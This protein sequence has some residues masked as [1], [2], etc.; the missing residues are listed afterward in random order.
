MHA[1]YLCFLG[2]L[3]LL[4]TMPK[5]D[6]PV[7]FYSFETNEPFSHCIECNT[8]LLD[9]KTEYLVEKA[10]KNYQGYKAT[11]VIFDYAICMDCAESRRKAISSESMRS[12]MRYFQA[13]IS[14]EMRALH[15]ERSATENLNHCLVKGISREECD[16]F[17]IFAHCVGRQLHESNP[18]YMVCSQV[19]E[20][21]ITELSAKTIDEMNGFLTKHFSPDPSFFNTTPKLVL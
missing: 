1:Y 9:E 3:G 5:S 4:L 12:I 16:E 7:D 17:Q 14:E 11:D 13:N 20:E 8:W 6:I 19:V 2:L 10:I 15:V 21:L 18:P